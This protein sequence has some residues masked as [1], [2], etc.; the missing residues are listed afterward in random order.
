[1]CFSRVY[2]VRQAECRIEL[3][4][5]RQLYRWFSR[6]DLR[7]M[8]RHGSFLR[9]LLMHKVQS[10]TFPSDQTTILIDP[11]RKGCDESFLKQ[12]L[13]FA[14][15]RIVC[16]SS[17]DILDSHLI[18]TPPQVYV[19]CNVHTQARDVGYLINESKETYKLD[20]IRGCDLFPQTY[21]VESLAVLSRSA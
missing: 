17:G 8:A 15:A 3:D 6:R 2:Q 13:A 21:H 1:M 11:P 5:E 18:P 16:R 7:G 20:S 19:S 14:P 4:Q 10:L 9:T 12:L